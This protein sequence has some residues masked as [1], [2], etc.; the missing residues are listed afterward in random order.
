MEYKK[1]RV[2]FV[3]DEPMILLNAD[4]WFGNMG[5]DAIITGTAEE[6]GLQTFIR[7]YLLFEVLDTPDEES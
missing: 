6:T 4:F 5:A 1:I 7:D 2:R 3:N